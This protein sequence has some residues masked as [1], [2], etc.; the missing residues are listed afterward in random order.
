MP[1][2]PAQQRLVNRAIAQMRLF[3]RQR[4]A[5]ELEALRNELVAVRADTQSKLTA[6]ESEF[7][8]LSELLARVRADP[9]SS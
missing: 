4:Y 1:L 3:E 5:A 9:G 8:R 2:E 7:V 6:M